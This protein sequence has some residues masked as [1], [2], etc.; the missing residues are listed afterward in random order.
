MAGKSLAP[1]T[2]R[3]ATPGLALERALLP[4]YVV[5]AQ[6]QLREAAAAGAQASSAA[7]GRA[8]TVPLQQTMN[9][10]R[11]WRFFYQC[12]SN[13]RQIVDRAAVWPGRVLVDHL[14][15]RSEEAKDAEY[16]AQQLIEGWERHPMNNRKIPVH[17][18]LRLDSARALG[19]A[20]F[21]S[22]S[23]SDSEARAEICHRFELALESCDEFPKSLMCEDERR[24]MRLRVMCWYADFLAR[25]PR[26][27]EKITGSEWNRTADGLDIEIWKDRDYWTSDS[28]QC[29]VTAQWLERQG[30]ERVSAADAADD[31]TLGYTLYK[32]D[33]QQFRFK[34]LGAAKVGGSMPE[35][36]SHWL[37]CP[38]DPF[39]DAAKLALTCSRDERRAR[40][41]QEGDRLRGYWQA[42]VNVLRTFRVAQVEGFDHAVWAAFKHQGLV[43]KDDKMKW[44]SIRRPRFPR[45][46]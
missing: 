14:L 36:L 34:A 40:S 2:A 10:L 5:E 46:R 44:I 21:G 28:G 35:A 22:G 41:T 33:W 23:A 25:G 8:Y 32:L 31:Y 17:P 20:L 7:L 37:K 1:Y 29:A 43:T 3:R 45:D 26:V 13:E 27:R 18:V 42:A 30:D 11:G 4:A 6:L 9:E 24:W 19:A 16:I 12:V 15:G 38:D 39:E